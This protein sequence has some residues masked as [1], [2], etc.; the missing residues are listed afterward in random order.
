MVVDDGERAGALVATG[1]RALRAAG[2]QLEWRALRLGRG[3]CP[4][5]DGRFFV[6]LSWDLLGARCL[7]CGASPISTAIGWVVSRRVPDLARARVLELSSRGPFH[8]FLR[9]TL[10]GDRGTLT[11]CEYFDD[12]EPGG[13]RDG[14][15]CQDVQRLT[16]A[17]AS[18]DLCTSTEVFEHVPDDA[19]GFGELFRVLAP[20]GRLIF[21]VPLSSREETVERARRVDGEVVH[22]QEPSYHDDLIRG[23]ARVLVYRDYGRD[24]TA[25]V[26]RAGFADAHIESVPDA[27]GFG[28]V[29]HVVVARKP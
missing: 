27:A 20:G 9:R 14:V 18:F 11:D 3:R 21:T 19:R 29:A 12:L 5:C 24:V 17:D 23:A 25:R 6:R 1:L 2:R 28:C 7:A 8:A 15:Q 16:Y 22:L 4:L 10:A 13:W 26:A